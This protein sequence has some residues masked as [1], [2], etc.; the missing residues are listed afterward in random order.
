VAQG[1]NDP[2][3]NRREAEQ[4]VVAL[5]DR[6]F[7]V[8]YLLAPD[9]GHGFARP[10]NNMALY[11]AAEKFLAQHLGGRYQEGGTP[12]ATQRLAEIS[13]DPKT[14]T[15][16]KKVDAGAV[17]L[18]KPAVDLSPGTYK[19]KALI[20]AGAQQIPLKIST[21]IKED[22]GAWT[23]VDTM[24]GP[25]GQALD[26]TTIDKGTLVV[27]KRKVQQGPMMMNLDFTDK[28]A[29]GTM[30]MNGNEKPISADLGGPL[31]GDAAGAMEAIACLPLAEGYATSFRNFDVQKGKEKV[32]ALKVVGVESVTVPA[33]TFDSYKV[34]LSSVDGGDDKQ[35][36]WIAK[37]SRKPVK[38]SALMP[39]MGGATMTME[40][41]Q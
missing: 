14:V 23:A 37:D 5:R 17:G 8:E 35:T 21:T 20:A 26:T 4:I 12:E 2:R 18:P 41:T 22:S 16:A 32:M 9:E 3:V 7:P 15:V 6:G 29:S 10:V 11:M 13:V 30:S 24:E 31:F 40:L 1:A 34:E 28:K 33:G 19:Y 36:I 39:S 38:L 25:M 27:R